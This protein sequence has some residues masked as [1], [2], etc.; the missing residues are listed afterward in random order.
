[1]L[2]KIKNIA[3]LLMLLVAFSSCEEDN[4]EIKVDAIVSA[5]G[6]LLN[7][8]FPLQQVRV[9]GEGLSGLEKITLDNTIEVGFNPA[10]NSNRAFI[11]TVPF[12]ISEG[13][14]FGL[15]PITFQTSGGSFTT[16]FEIIQPVPV[17][18]SISP[19]T[20][21]VGNFATVEGE[22]FY[23]V[24]SVTFDGEPIE[25]SV[26][27][28]ESLT[29]LIPETATGGADLEITTPGGTVTQFLNVS[30][31]FVIINISDFDGGGVRQ[32]WFS[33]G[34]VESFDANVSGGPSGNYAQFTWAG[35]D[36]N[37]YNGTS[38]GGGNNFVD[39]TNTDPTE[40]Y[41]E[42]DISA[43]VVGAHV[44]IQLNE[45]D[46]A[47]FAYNM[48]I[49]DTE[50]N[51]YSIPLSEFKNNYGFGEV[52]EGNPDP[53]QVNQINVSIVQSDTPNPTTISFDNLKIKYRN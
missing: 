41:I 53:S 45:I 47:N 34:D 29:I 42:I 23:D 13:S 36:A 35:S 5:S 27:S 18:S 46:G 17:I 43:N 10:Y 31:G 11:F 3:I 16:D 30:L 50:W 51:T 52:V 1:M 25:Y 21:L 39:E 4:A 8:S 6:D 20:P 38:A 19:E 9:E 28:D 32:E 14:R 2:N 26:I 40:V 49:E 24:S 33:F 7:A 37:G 48:K 22:W 15:Q 12:D 44:A